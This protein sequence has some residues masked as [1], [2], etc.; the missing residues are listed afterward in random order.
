MRWNYH[1]ATCLWFRTEVVDGPLRQPLMDYLL[2]T[3]KN[4]V[5]DTKGLEN[6][7]EV[8]PCQSSVPLQT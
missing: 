1:N 5:Y 4:E 7:S 3:G 6:P 8:S 2:H